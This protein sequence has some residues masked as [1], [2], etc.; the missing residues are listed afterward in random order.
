MKDITEVYITGGGITMLRKDLL[1]IE[2]A[3]ILFELF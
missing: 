1:M 3:K 2:T